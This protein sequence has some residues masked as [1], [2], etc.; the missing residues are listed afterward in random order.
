M[1]S[2]NVL[3]ERRDG[4]QA[5]LGRRLALSRQTINEWPTKGIPIPYCAGVEAECKGEYR[6]WH[7]RPAD[8]H[9][10]WPELIGTDGAP[11]PAPAQVEGQAAHG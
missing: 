9:L 10:I 1:T 8:W 6:R 7:F 11:E 2:W 3:F 5:R 4:F